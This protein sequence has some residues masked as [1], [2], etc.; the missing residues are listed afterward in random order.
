ML[1]SK[2]KYIY[3]FFLCYLYDFH[4]FFSRDIHEKC[5]LKKNC[6]EVGVCP[7]FLQFLMQLTKV[8]DTFLC[9][10]GF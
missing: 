10:Y 1:H 5:E 9:N 2:K 8:S 7:Q 4:T 3:I 6:L